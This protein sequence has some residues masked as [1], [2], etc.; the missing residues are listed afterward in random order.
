MAKTSEASQ[1]EGMSL[2]IKSKHHL[3]SYFSSA[4][5]ARVGHRIGDLSL[6]F[7]GKV[8]PNIIQT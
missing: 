6:Y 8:K 1:K 7:L 5:R 2:V 3:L 4:R